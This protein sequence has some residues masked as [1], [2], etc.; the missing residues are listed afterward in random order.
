MASHDAIALF[1]RSGKVSGR[2]TR[3]GLVGTEVDVHYDRHIRDGKPGYCLYG[4]DI[5]VHSEMFN[6]P[7][8]AAGTS[9]Q[10]RA[11]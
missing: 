7:C 10:P 4:T 9:A 11:P 2:E 5:L 1:E 8:T 6:D 3:T